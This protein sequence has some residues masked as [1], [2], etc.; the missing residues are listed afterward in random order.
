[1]AIQTTA[2]PVMPVP[3]ADMP[4]AMVALIEEIKGNTVAAPIISNCANVTVNRVDGSI[5]NATARPIVARLEAVARPPG[6][7]RNF[8]DRADPLRDIR[9]ELQS[10]GGADV[11]GVEGCGMTTL[12]RQAANLP[13]DP[14]LRDG[15]L[16]VPRVERLDDLLPELFKRFYHS[17]DGQSVSPPL[18]RTYLAKVRALFVLDG[19]PLA[20][21]ELADL[22]DIL[23]DNAVLVGGLPLDPGGDTLE[24]LHGVVLAGLPR[25][26]A[27]ALLQREASLAETTPETARLVE[28]LCDLFGDLPLPLRLVGRLLRAA[29]VPLPQ[30]VTVASERAHARVVGAPIVQPAIAPLDLAIDLACTALDQRQQALLAVLVRIGSPSAGLEALSAISHLTTAVVESSLRRA[31]LLGL[32]RVSSDRY[33][34]F[35]ASVARALDRRLPAG[36]ERR[37]AAAYFAAA[38]LTHQGDLAWFTRESSNIL[39]AIKTLLASGQPAEAGALAQATQ[40]ALV[41]HGLWGSWGTVID[42]AS[43]AART[44]GNT[45]LRAWALHER[46]TRAGLYGDLQTATMDLGEAR[47][48]RGR[49]GDQQGA[50]TSAHNMRQLGLLPPTPPNDSHSPDADPPPDEAGP[51]SP[52]LPLWQWIVLP[53]VA[54]LVIIMAVLA[55]DAVVAAPVFSA[56]PASGSFPLTVV[57][58]A[59]ASAAAKYEW[60]FGDG[61][62]Q[63]TTTPRISHTYPQ[64]GNYQASLLLREANGATMPAAHTLI[65]V[66]NNAPVA[67]IAI[68][69]NPSDLVAGQSLIL[70]GAARDDEDGFLPGDALAWSVTMRH[71]AEATP[72]LEG[73]H[74]ADVSVVVPA[75]GAPLPAGDTTLE[76]RL[77]AA[78]SLGAQTT[79][80]RVLRLAA[81]VVR[82]DS[83]PSGLVLLV[84]ERKIRTPA[85][86]RLPRAATLQVDAPEQPDAQGRPLIFEGW[87]DG[88]PARHTITATA[89]ES[90]RAV[91]HP[92]TV[93]F[94]QSTY[95]VSEAAGAATINIRLADPSVQEQQFSYATS[96]GSATAGQD[97]VAIEG[98][99]TIPPGMT[100]ASIIVPIRD[101]QLDQPDRELSVTLFGQGGSEVQTAVVVIKDDDE[102]PAAQ[103]IAPAAVPESDGRI[104]ATV[105]LDRPSGREVRIGY[106][107]SGGDATPNEDYQAVAGTLTFASGEISQVI[108]IPLL[109]DQQAEPEEHF[110]LALSD[111]VNVTLGGAETPLTIAA[112]QVPTLA[113]SCPTYKI[114]LGGEA[115]QFECL[116]FDGTNLHIPVLLSQPSSQR[117]TVDWSLNATGSVGGVESRTVGA[118][119]AQPAEPGP[120]AG[121]LT[122]ETREMSKEILLDPRLL[123]NHSTAPATLTLANPVGATLGSPAQATIVIERIV[124]QAELQ[125]TATP[126]TPNLKSCA[127]D[128]T[129]TAVVSG[130]VLLTSPVQLRYQIDDGEQQTQAMEGDGTRFTTQIT[131][132]AG[133]TITYSVTATTNDAVR[134]PPDGRITLDACNI[135]DTTAPTIEIIR[136]EYTLQQPSCFPLNLVVTARV[137]DVGS[138]V[139]DSV[140]LQ[141]R[142]PGTG[143]WSQVHMSLDNGVYSGFITFDPPGDTLEYQVVAEDLAGN[144]Q[145]SEMGMLTKGCGVD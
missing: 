61:T 110:N 29:T 99:V 141:A 78:D 94:D 60:D 136:A 24:T 88:K 114:I 28:Q 21:S 31:L 129:F 82:F 50:A 121:S 109:A 8:L 6:L 112:D 46:G 18:A 30:L 49:L 15:V 10:T 132:P 122:F 48:L 20:P 41:L 13:L 35:S 85:D 25:V 98:V 17:T 33:E 71:G 73:K 135:P 90:Y 57:F 76:I 43:Q 118:L 142:R 92:L 54:S 64:P 96:D 16:I 101:N 67:Q 38:A 44:T 127:V 70:H 58:D 3:R 107:T 4:G 140:I 75:V 1:M 123:V 77:V 83:E 51:P 69:G 27:V 79:T 81:V 84:G 86:L 47:R 100:G 128:V 87:S 9:T 124:R 104:V 102:P 23:R 39:A 5:L 131:A 134:L 22:V 89:A 137:I 55:R 32:V 7:M 139:A 36:D 53:L 108:E 12:L 2:A 34:I 68:E 111:P 95:D 115:P 130:D 11:R 105:T 117:V 120:S 42:S 63:T 19:L 65:T 80:T 103:I 145:V 40:P 62:T 74:G 144:Q 14:S 93:A 116:T 37:R 91:F 143:Q 133:G 45:A 126:A 52:R 113:F 72:L 106:A 125:L 26:D 119:A 66:L 59:A 56:S 138:G 97:Y